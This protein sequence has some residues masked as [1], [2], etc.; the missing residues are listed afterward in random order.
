LAVVDSD[1]D[2]SCF[3][4]HDGARVGNHAVQQIFKL[5]VRPVA[6]GLQ[7]GLDEINSLHTQNAC[8][9]SSP[10]LLGVVSS[11]AGEHEREVANHLVVLK[12]SSRLEVDVLVGVTGLG[13]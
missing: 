5:A 4:G 8:V 10:S 1:E 6:V 13:K 3:K 7:K 11:P 12:P 2:S 9:E